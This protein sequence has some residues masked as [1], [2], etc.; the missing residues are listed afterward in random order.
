MVSIHWTFLDAYILSL[1]DGTKAQIVQETSDAT[2][3]VV[4]GHVDLSQVQWPPG[5]REVALLGNFNRSLD[6]V[7]WPSGLERLWFGEP[8]RPSLQTYR[9]SDIFDKPLDGVT[10]PYGL[11]EIFLGDC[12]DQPIEGIAW[13]G[14]LERLSLPGFNHS[15]RDVQWPPGLKALEF[16]SPSTIRLWQDGGPAAEDFIV[17]QFGISKGY[18]SSS[19]PGYGCFNQELG[20]TLPP[21]LERLWLSSTYDQPLDGVACP[22]GVATLGLPFHSWSYNFS[23]ITLPS[24]VKTL[25]SVD[26][27][28]RAIRLPEGAEVKILEPY[29]ERSNWDDDI[30]SD[31]W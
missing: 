23:R 20:S 5:T 24:S 19:P 28:N 13:P 17:F 16:L 25:F 10:F 9:I 30:F 29:G 4:V 27:V 31:D 11:R 22:N 2:D 8:N 21:S 14:G 15:I 12:F 7:P 6:D 26:K 1:L 18:A 3:L